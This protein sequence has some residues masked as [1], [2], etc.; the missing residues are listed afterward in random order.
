MRKTSL[1]LDH[2]ATTPN[3]AS[4]FVWEAMLRAWLS[5]PYGT[6]DLRML[7]Q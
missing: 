3:P 2:G 6:D 7:V 1:L 4:L 5:Q